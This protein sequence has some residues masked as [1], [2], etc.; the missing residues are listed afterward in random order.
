M[1][2]PADQSAAASRAGG[3]RAEEPAARSNAGGVGAAAAAA[4]PTLFSVEHRTVS[5]VSG[6][7]LI[8]DHVEGVG[9]NE[10]VEVISPSGEVRRGQVLEVDG[11]R[12]V[13]QV[14]GGTRGLDVDLTAVR[15]RGE[16]TT[17]GVGR[18]LV[19]RILDGSGRPIDDG[20]PLAPIAYRDVNGA[21]INPVVRANPSEFIETGVSA[22]DALNTLVRGQKLPLFSGF[23]LPAMELAARIAAHARV[24]SAGEAADEFVVVFGAIGITQREA[25]FFRRSFASTGALERAVLFLNLADDPT[26]ERLLTPRAALTV[27]EQLGFEEGMHVLVILTDITNY[28]E[29]L[30]EIAAA[31]EEIPGR[32]G[33]PGYM[34]TDLASL[35]ERAGRLHG[36][37]GSVTQLIILSMPD[38]DLTHP[39]PDLTGSITEGQIVLSRAL[40]RRGI[41]PPID[42][43]P[44][45]SRLMNAGIG[46]GKTREDHRAAAD[47]LYALVARAAELRRLASII[48]ESALTNADRRYLPFAEDFE[49]RFVGQGPARRTIEESLDLAWELFARFGDDDL[50]RISAPLMTRYGRVPTGVAATR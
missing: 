34:Y 44:S 22:I 17:I 6:P 20:P 29:A 39:I 47:Q 41:D 12:A 2:G 5:A 23:G 46:A 26:I 45:L 43:L 30:R 8:A 7:L 19:G 9:Y 49:R 50:K 36:R 15:S 28:C 4:G 13:L 14:L 48:G 33:Y 40:D 11:S 18:D 42:V 32:R 38:D 35:F 27:A 1:S 37:T 31:R 10:S 3:A 16:L 24:R 25:S 21:P